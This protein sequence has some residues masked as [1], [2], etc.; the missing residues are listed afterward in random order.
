MKIVFLFFLLNLFFFHQHKN[1]I[2]AAAEQASATATVALW[3][4]PAWSGTLNAGFQKLR[5]AFKFKKDTTGKLTALMVSIDQGMSELVADKVRFEKNRLELVFTKKKG[6]YTGELKNNPA[7]VEGYWQ[8]SLY[9]LPLNLKPTLKDIRPA[10]PQEPKPPFPYKTEEVKVKNGEDNITLAGTLTIPAQKGKVPGVVLITG[11]GSQDRDETIFSH[12][13]FF[14]LADHLARAGIASLR[15]DDRGVGK[16]EGDPK[17]ATTFDFVKDIRAAYLFFKKRAEIEQKQIGL[18]GHSEGGLIAPILAATQ[19]DIS[20]IVLL[21]GTAFP[22]DEILFQQNRDIMR[23][24]GLSEERIAK[25]IKRLKRAFFYIVYERDAKLAHKKLLQL[26]KTNYEGTS[27]PE[28]RSKKVV[29]TLLS[30]WFKT[31]L[32]L[33]PAPYLAKVNCPVLSLIGSKDLQVNA[34]INLGEMRRIFQKKPEVSF[35]AYELE[36]LNHLF[37]KC[38]T[39]LVQEYGKIEQT[40]SPVALKKITAWIKKIPKE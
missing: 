11:S 29:A 22:G 34:R 3:D 8:Q 37:Q 19:P 13:P 20:F 5:I 1:F 4:V 40:F 36:G 26:Y 9:K 15:L 38:Q 2:L 23:Q 33:D 18:I 6:K 12:R 25:K 21:A 14:I 7:R 27:L 17:K 24:A 35:T 16:S 10:R 31:F 28:A 30:P 39:G 32:S